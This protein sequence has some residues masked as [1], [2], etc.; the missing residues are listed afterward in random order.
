M[1]SEISRYRPLPDE[2]IRDPRRGVVA[3]KAL[4]LPPAP[5]G[6]LVHTVEEGDRLDHLGYK[7]YRQPRDWWRIADAN[8][9]HLSP[10][11]LLG[12]DPRRESRIPVRWT[13]PD[14]PWSRLV[15]ALEARAGVASARTGA[16]G[17]PEPTVEH[18]EGPAL[19]TVE[20]PSIV[21]PL[22]AS[23]DYVRTGG[24]AGARPS[25]AEMA[26]RLLSVL[27]G[28]GVAP[29]GGIA[30]AAVGEASWRVAETAGERLFVLRLVDRDGEGPLLSVHRAIRA[31]AWS[32][33]V[34]HDRLEATPAELA[35]WIE[36]EGFDPGAPTG[37]GRTGKPVAVPPRGG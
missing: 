37:V 21:A 33:T 9:E 10:E 35:G 7:Y 5:E 8:P 25:T 30:L 3:S 27:E 14:P 23:R 13:G 15:R 22:D 24:E 6:A 4:R 36:G 11:E 1:F 18:R 32:V 20:D 31:H 16:G 19:F 17:A 26:A 2:T 29:A 28:G 12:R 34:V